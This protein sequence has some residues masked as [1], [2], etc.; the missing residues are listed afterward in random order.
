MEHRHVCV[1]AER[2]ERIEIAAGCSTAAVLVYF[3]ISDKFS[4]AELLRME[5]SVNGTRTASTYKF[6]VDV[7]VN[8]DIPK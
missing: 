4:S 5:M 3:T 7:H 2:T 1:T 8:C 6:K